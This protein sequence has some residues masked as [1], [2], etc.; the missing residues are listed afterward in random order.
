MLAASPWLQY[1]RSN[2]PTPREEV[3]HESHSAARGCVRVLLAHAGMTPAWSSNWSINA[4]INNPV[5]TAQDRQQSSRA[6]SDGGSGVIV[7]W[8][9]LRNQLFFDVYAQRINGND[10]SK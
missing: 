5:S 8:Q 10:A 4:G 3:P 6:I 1:E 2:R 7:T 9:D